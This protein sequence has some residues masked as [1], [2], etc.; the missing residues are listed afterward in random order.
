LF[1]SVH[2]ARQI[3]VVRVNADAVRI[4]AFIKFDV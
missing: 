1:L 4:T 3:V 2:Y